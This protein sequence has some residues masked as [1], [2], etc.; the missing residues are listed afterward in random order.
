MVF[1][2]TADRTHQQITNTRYDAEDQQKILGMMQMNVYKIKIFECDNNDDSTEIGPGGIRGCAVQHSALIAA[3]DQL[4]G[5]DSK[6]LCTE[7]LPS[8]LRH[9]SSHSLQLS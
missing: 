4:N 6:T 9:I 8:Q 5:N 7:V 2:Y 1:A 3:Q